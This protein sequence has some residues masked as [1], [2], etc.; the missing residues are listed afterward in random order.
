MNKCTSCGYATENT[1]NF[2]P[3]C[4][5]KIESETPTYAEV[6]VAPTYGTPIQ[7]PSK[8]KII[9][10]MAISIES[11]ATAIIMFFYTMSIAAI[12]PVAGL[13]FGLVTA[14]INLPLGIVGLVLS[15]D[16][17]EGRDTPIFCRLGKIFGTISVILTSVTLFFALVIGG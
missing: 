11:F 15:K 16:I 2:C 8:G 9:A 7:R 6:V 3:V 10:G 12:D 4:G 13:I 17:T 5:G 14:I 1:I